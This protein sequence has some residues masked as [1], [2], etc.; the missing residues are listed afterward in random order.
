M[1]ANRVTLAAGLGMLAACA[2]DGPG[3]PPHVDAITAEALSADLHALSA[4]SMR[5][6][7][8]GTPEIAKA[9]DWVGARF[10]ELGLQPAGTSGYFE[11]FDLDWFT[12]G[13]GNA[14]RVGTGTPS[15]VGSGWYPR[16][17]SATGSAQGEVVF[18]GFGIVEPRVSWDDYGDADLT[19][20]VVLVL[21]GEPGPDDPASPFDGVVTSEASRDWRKVVAAQERGAVA[22]LFVRDVNS[23]GGNQDLAAAAAGYWPDEP[24]RVERFSLGVWMDRVRVPVAEV[25]VDL[26]EGLVA[27]TGRPLAQLATDAEASLGGLGVMELPG[28]RVSVTT[29][30]ERHVV[31]ARNILAMVEGSDPALAGEVVI[32]AGHHDHNGA[33]GDEIFNGAD[34]DGSG[35]IGVLAVAR[36]YALGMAEGKRPRRSV[37]F[38][39]WDAEERGLLGAWYHAERPRAPLSNV[40]AVLNLDMIGRNEE[41][42]ESGGPRFRG[43]EP[44]TAASNANAINILGHTRTPELAAVVQAANGQVGLDLRLRYDNNASNLLRRSDHWPFLQNGVPA[45]WFHTGLHPDYHTDRD[46]ADRIE[47][48]KMESVVKLVLRSSWAVANADGRPSMG[49]H[50]MGDG[51]AN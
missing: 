35:T 47:Y 13:A 19:G 51:I 38:A 48:G 31:P 33:D 34:D 26:A 24:R 45:L 21:D 3:E 50:P 10:E 2:P 41:V 7:L 43:L 29:A 11:P 9:A 37:V 22:V 42:P 32:V 39:V 17:V 40:V 18:A 6:R 36:A 14:L 5:G 4:D 1:R 15:P 28:A 49:P 23:R 25:S 44:Q 46:D 16:N 20:K 8:V 30:V 27:G 12:L